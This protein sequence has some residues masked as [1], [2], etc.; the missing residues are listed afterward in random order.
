MLFFVK[1]S[2]LLFV[3]RVA[4]YIP[5]G[6][7]RIKLLTKVEDKLSWVAERKVDENDHMIWQLCIISS[8]LWI[9]SR[10]LLFLRKMTLFRRGSKQI[11][12][13]SLW[14]VCL[15][16]IFV[17]KMYYL[18]TNLDAHCL[19]KEVLSMLKWMPREVNRYPGGSVWLAI[20]LVLYPRTFVKLDFMNMFK[21]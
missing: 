17:N 7:S 3:Y 19:A 10:I 11:A 5:K 6:F 2:V 9:I 12:H 15:H 1:R 18:L 21:G 14:M 8:I 13:V 16:T 20:F 4:L